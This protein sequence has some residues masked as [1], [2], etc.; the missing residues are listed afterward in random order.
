M[1]RFNLE[2][3]VG[4]FVVLGLAA[5][6]YLSIRLGQLQ[7][8]PGNT[9][10]LTAVFPTVGSLRVGA[11]IEIAGVEVGRVQAYHARQLCRSREAAA[12]ETGAIARGCYCIHSY[13]WTHW[14]TIRLLLPRGVRSGFWQPEDVS[15]RSNPRLTSRP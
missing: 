1:N 5:L 12:E 11:G 15:V 9:Y 13:A 8:G 6:G 4:L 14:G 3:T 7:I 10:D 2:V